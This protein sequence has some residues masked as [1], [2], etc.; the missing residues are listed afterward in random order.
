ML[1]IWVLT[2][3]LWLLNY[4]WHHEGTTRGGCI[5][6]HVALSGVPLL[7]LLWSVLALVFWFLPHR[8]L[9]LRI[10]LAVAEALV[11]LYLLLVLLQISCGWCILRRRLLSSRNGRALA[12]GLLAGAAG[13]ALAALHQIALTYA[14]MVLFL[15][16]LCVVLYNANWNAEEY[17]ARLPYAGQLGVD[18]CV[19]VAHKLRLMELFKRMAFGYALAESFRLLSAVFARTAAQT[20]LGEV[21]DAALVLG[22]LLLLRLRRLPHPDEL[23]AKASVL[24]TRSN[25]ALLVLRLEPPHLDGS[26][27]PDADSIM[28]LAVRSDADRKLVRRCSDRLGE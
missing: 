5:P 21:L 11:R 15:L 8:P 20:L 16:A 22:L 17:V 14:G 24:D 3:F 1:T 18:S 12:L 6:L 28:L 2:S 19:E 26:P 13:A 7:K 25:P 4:L 27:V 9:A 10:V 23:L